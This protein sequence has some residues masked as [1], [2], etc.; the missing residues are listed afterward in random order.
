MAKQNDQ[1]DTLYLLYERRNSPTKL[2]LEKYLAFYINH[3]D[4]LQP[5]Q[6]ETFLLLRIYTLF[7][8]IIHMTIYS[9]INML[10]IIKKELLHNLE[11]YYFLFSTLRIPVVITEQIIS[12]TFFYIKSLPSLQLL[13]KCY[14]CIANNVISK[15]KRLQINEEYT[16]PTGWQGHVVCV[17]FVRISLTHIVIRIDNPS[18]L[19]LPNKHEIYPSTDGFTRI[20]PKVLGQLHVGNL[21]NNL[22]YF[23][24][25]TDSVKRDLTREEGSSLIYNENRQILH[26]EEMAIEI[27]PSFI[28][29]A[30]D[31][32]VV[33]CFELGF[34]LRVDKIHKELYHELLTSEVKN[35]CV[36]A[37]L[38]EEEHQHYSDEILGQF[39]LLAESENMG[40]L[41]TTQ[42]LDFQ[43][44]LKMSYK[45][46]YKYLSSNENVDP[47]S[48][49]NEKYI[50]LRFETNISTTDQ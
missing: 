18:S 39:I 46:H 45:Q 42:V 38:C 19:K 33:E 32:C 43:D 48:L 50:P 16:I 8:K 24:L 12:R 49:L 14:E 13:I 29:Q 6:N 10:E 2:Q 27:M 5:K 23:V 47:C 4:R 34:R 40:T 44:K 41:P 37:R 31:N 7:Q 25:L 9:K 35:A 36:L 22:D 11:T 20:I 15:I 21:Q 1:C 3:Y 26:L 28:Q 30:N 17:S